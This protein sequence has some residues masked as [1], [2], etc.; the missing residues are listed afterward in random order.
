MLHAHIA[1][2]GGN[3][4]ANICFRSLFGKYSKVHLNHL[5][6]LR[7]LLWSSA[8]ET[9]QSCLEHTPET[10]DFCCEEF[11]TIPERRTFNAVYSENAEVD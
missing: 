9:G 5:K 4:A 1:S 11:Q 8:F 6:Y 3:G 2:R 10:S 7:P